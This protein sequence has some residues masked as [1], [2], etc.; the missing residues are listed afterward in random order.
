MTALGRRKP[1]GHRA[2]NGS[3]RVPVSCRMYPTSR[4]RLDELAAA[5]GIDRSDL[6]RR[7]CA[8]G[9]HRDTER[10]R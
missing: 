10:A 8:E 1:K 5:Q 4:D 6:I 9:I 2:Q 7:Y 3:G